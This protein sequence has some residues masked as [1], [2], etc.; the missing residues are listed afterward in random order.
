MRP[1]RYRS[2]VRGGT[3]VKGVTEGPGRSSG[4]GCRTPQKL[5]P[6]SGRLHSLGRRGGKHEAE[7]RAGLERS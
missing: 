7:L 5:R 1:V 6:P 2:E 3:G 4:P